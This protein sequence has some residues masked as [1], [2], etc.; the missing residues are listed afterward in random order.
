MRC[1]CPLRTRMVIAL[2]PKPAASTCFR[3]TTPCC[4][5][6]VS[7]TRRSGVSFFA[8]IW[9]HKSTGPLPRPPYPAAFRPSERLRYALRGLGDLARLEA[10]GADVG[11]EGAA[12]LLDP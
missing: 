7:A 8:P 11:A 9:A 4:L 5:A 3:V 6:A 1:S 12:V 2:E 10:A